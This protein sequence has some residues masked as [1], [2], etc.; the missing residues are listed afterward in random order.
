MATNPSAPKAEHDANGK[1]LPLA[2][3][4]W[5]LLAASP[6]HADGLGKFS[7]LIKSKMPPDG[8]TYK[9]AK[10][11]GD[12]EFE[13]DDVVVT[14]PPDATAGAKAEPIEIKSIVV[15]EADF[16]QIAK[17]APPNFL[18]MRIGIDISSKPAEGIDLQR[19]RR[20]RQGQR[21]YP[22]RLPHR[23]DRRR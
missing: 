20:D 3:C 6:G 7:D 10:A 23:P 18:K 9:S 1:G 19:A 2:A 8:L 17:R 14:P 22:A 4:A 5:I 15:D 21:R 16:D 12:S 13:L 11:L